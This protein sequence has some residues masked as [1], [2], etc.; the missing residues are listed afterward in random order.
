M[1]PTAPLAA[2]NSFHSDSSIRLA[3][4]AHA[5]SHA[6]TAARARRHAFEVHRDRHTREEVDR[7]IDCQRDRSD[8]SSADEQETAVMLRR[9]DGVLRRCEKA[10]D[11]GDP[12]AQDDIAQAP[13]S[14]GHEDEGQNE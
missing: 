9:I 14:D 1:A 6:G 3:T 11:R 13:A 12:A 10:C 4:Q 5:N 2:A 7:K 8:R